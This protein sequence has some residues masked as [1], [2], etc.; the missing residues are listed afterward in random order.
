MCFTFSFVSGGVLFGVFPS[1]VE[2]ISDDM[3]H[4]PI[5]RV[6]TVSLAYRPSEQGGPPMVPANA[7][8]RNTNHFYCL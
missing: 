4:G 1:P 6:F 2:E 7:N 8:T 5:V 3:A